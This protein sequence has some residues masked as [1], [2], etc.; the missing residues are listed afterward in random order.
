MANSNKSESC[1]TTVH[2]DI[3]Q[4]AVAHSSS[5]KRRIVFVHACN[6]VGSW[7]AGIAL[8][9]K[10]R[11][12]AQFRVYRDWC[13]SH[14][15]PSN[16]M[17]G[18]R[19]REGDTGYGG[20]GRYQGARGRG[21]GNSISRGNATMRTSGENQPIEP[22]SLIGTC[23]L[24]QPPHSPSSDNDISIY[25]ACLFTSQAYGRKKDTPEEILAA[26][27]EALGDL[28]M[29]LG[30]GANNLDPETTSWEIHSWYV[31]W[32]MDGSLPH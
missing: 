1:I 8:A 24:I 5:S 17:A 2:G 19:N 23:L 18:P 25:I 28:K 4:L 11:F 32:T 12:P 7:G 6:A 16:S 30:L 26:T 31:Q 20:R 22:R 14:Q 10:E 27:R 3:F 9:F 21:R 15:V 13:L 29:Q